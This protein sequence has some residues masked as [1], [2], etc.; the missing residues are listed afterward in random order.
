M[1]PWSRKKTPSPPPAPPPP[2]PAPTPR[3][4][5]RP[6]TP[7][8]LARIPQ[9]RAALREGDW[10]AARELG[11]LGAQEAVTDLIAALQH[12]KIG[13]VAAEALADIGDPRAIPA[14]HYYIEHAD[15]P[16]G[17]DGDPDERSIAR[18]ALER[19]VARTR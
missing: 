12:P 18:A 13:A 2:A 4:P 1:W 10:A 15:P 19:L 7:E 9:L 6:P 14:I 3:R 11:R 5:P 16:D 17:P 8:E